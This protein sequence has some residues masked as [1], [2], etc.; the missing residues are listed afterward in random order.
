MDPKKLIPGLAHL[1]I[2]QTYRLH[3]QQGVAAL[4]DA[5]IQFEIEEKLPIFEVIIEMVIPCLT[6]HVFGNPGKGQIVCCHQADCTVS[7]EGS[8]EQFGSLEPIMRICPSEKLIEQ[9]KHGDWASGQIGN[10]L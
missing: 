5:L 3:E 10:H 1:L 4:H 2:Q 6:V 9:K 7:D 8:D